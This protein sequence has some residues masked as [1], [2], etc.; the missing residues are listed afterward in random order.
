MPSSRMLHR[1]AHVR[2]DISE[3]RIAT[4]IRVTRID[5]LGTTLAAT[6]SVLR[7]LVTADGVSSSPILVTLT[8]EEMHSSETSLRTR[9]TRLNIPEYCVLY[10]NFNS[11]IHIIFKI[12]IEYIVYE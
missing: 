12:L 1:V 5:E 4:I 8:M 3:E 9:A 10:Y 11:I 7:L 2:S 6:R